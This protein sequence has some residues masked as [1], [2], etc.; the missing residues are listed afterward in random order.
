MGTKPWIKRL[1]ETVIGDDTQAYSLYSKADSYAKISDIKKPQKPIQIEKP[2]NSPTQT[3]QF[4]SENTFF[5]FY[6]LY[7]SIQYF[8]TVSI[9]LILKQLILI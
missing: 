9:Q 3:I 4:W 1:V 5:F 2:Y 7:Y 6:H 8:G